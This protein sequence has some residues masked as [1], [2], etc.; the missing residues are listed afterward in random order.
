MIRAAAVPA[1]AGLALAVPA[2]AQAA[3]PVCPSVEFTMFPG[4]SLGL[5]AP[6]CT[7][8]EG[9]SFSVSNVTAPAHGTVSLDARSYTPNTGFHGWDEFTY[10]V[11]DADGEISAPAKVR[12]LVDTAP[13]CD[14]ASATVPANGVLVLADLPC[15]DPNGDAVTIVVDDPA[16]GT[17]S[18]PDNE[19]IVYTPTPGYSGTDSFPYYA[20]DEFGLES[21]LAATMRIRVVAAPAATPLPGPAATPVPTPPKDL[22]APAV[23]LAAKK[24]TLA[25]GVPV[26]LSVS[27]NAS[28]TLAL[29]LDQK[30]ARRLKLSRTVGTL[31][32]ALTPGTKTL[33]IKLT[34]K[35]RKALKAVKRAKLTLTAVVTDTAGNNT[36]KTLTVRLKR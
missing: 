32:A 34:A 30:T 36:T 2:T 8:P 28:A 33:A 24:A 35:A 12:I 26:T 3:P 4:A 20:E 14:D 6:T 22:T 16:H 18:F 23:T 10:Q 27:E 13:E 11:T 29:T 25:K 31:K 9:K 7:D 19:T 17:I 5:P 15:D 21:Y 1:L